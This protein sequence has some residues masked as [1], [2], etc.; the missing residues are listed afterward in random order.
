MTEVLGWLGR[1][2]KYTMGLES[3]TDA[4]VKPPDQGE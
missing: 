2:E 4:E 3:K 1:G